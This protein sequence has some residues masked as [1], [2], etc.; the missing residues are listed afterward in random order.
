MIVLS[1]TCN[2]FKLCMSENEFDVCILAGFHN[3]REYLRQRYVSYCIIVSV[4]KPG[5]GLGI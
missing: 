1:V 5:N 2:L 4:G 3:S